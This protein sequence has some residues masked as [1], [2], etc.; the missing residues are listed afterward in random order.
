M[1]ATKLA[2][3]QL[4]TL[5]SRVVSTVSVNTSMGAAANTEY[6]YF[7][8][9][10]VTMTLPTA[11]SNTSKYIV[12]NIGGGVVS[13]ATTSSQTIDGGAAPITITRQNNSLD[14]IS[15]GSNFKIV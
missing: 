2:D 5:Y 14:F 7:I 11:T 12:K 8:T 4:L 6:I 3:R 9:G 10:S 13:I 15:D 1:A